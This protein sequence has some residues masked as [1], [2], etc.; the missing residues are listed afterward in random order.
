VNS[1]LVPA[2]IAAAGGSAMVSAVLVTEYRRVQAMRASRV[3]VG[4]RFPLLDAADAKAA[5]HAISGMPERQELIFELQADG[6][7]I[8]HGLWVP[9][10]SQMSLTASL[11]GLLAGLRVSSAD[12]PKGRVTLAMRVLVPTPSVL[13]SESPEAAS[14]TL[15][16]GLSS[17]SGDGESVVLRWAAQPGVAR[18]VRVAEPTGSR[19]R[20]VDRVWRAKTASG[21]G[22][23]VAGLLL[24]RSGSLARSRA[25]CEHVASCL[26]S[27]RGSV[28]ALRLITL[29]GRPGFDEM[30]RTSTSSGWLSPAEFLGL[31]GWPLGEELIAGVEMAVSRQIAP[32]RALAREGRPLFTAERHGKPV[33]VAL[34][35][36]G[37]TR[38][39]AVLGASGGGKSTLLAAGIVSRIAAGDAGVVIDPKD[40]LVATILDRVRDGGER[41]AVLDPSAAL[42]PGVDLFA[43]GDPD[44]RAETLVSIFQSLF[45]DA[46]GPRTDAYLRLGVRTLAEVPGSSLLDLPPLLQNPHARRRAIA[47]LS[48]PLLIGQWQSFEALSESERAQHLQAPLSRVL[49]LVTRPPVQAVFGPDPKLDVGRFLEEQRGWLLVPLSSGIIGSASARIIG[50]ALTSIVWSTIAAR[51]AIAPAKRRPLHL[52]VDELQ[53]ITDQGI[54]L[55]DL[56]EQSRGYGASVTV[57]T[58]AI[59]RTPEQIRHSLLSN[60]GTLIA[61]RSGAEESARIAKELPGLAARDVQSLAPYEVVAR[62]AAGGGSGSIVVT[63]HTEPLGPPVGN[64]QSIR[65]RSAQ[66]WGRSREEVQAAIRAR[67]GATA[68]HDDVEGDVG[69]TARRP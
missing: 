62:V 46:W 36:A 7:G 67:Y 18:S 27:R 31:V 69:R 20:D 47:H 22:F 53:A 11:T 35:R 65:D 16:A 17:L 66:R 33:P 34:D 10:S 55:E 49:S 58:Q 3:Y 29:R 64:G 14:R 6:H 30:P 9:R 48:D 23:R 41:I 51:A 50:S 52:F 60:V 28:G 32:H 25:V 1:E 40:D 21:G 43:R 4:L 38:H 68:A 45:K 59:G 56:L 19:E 39:V 8:R 24:V 15:L 63:G 57:A 54:G 2:V 61:F 13:M 5:L 12:A 44:L 37:E 42:V 26:R